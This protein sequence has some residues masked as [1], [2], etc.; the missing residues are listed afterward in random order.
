MMWRPILFLSA[1]LIGVLPR[2]SLD[3]AAAQ[4]GPTLLAPFVGFP[5]ADDPRLKRGERLFNLH[6][7]P[8]PPESEPGGG[9]GPYFNRNACSA[10]HPKGGRGKAPSDPFEPLLTA[11]IRLSV[12]GA[13]DNGAPAPHPAFGGQL[14]TR[15]LPGLPEEPT[16]EISYRIIN[17]TYPDG[18]PYRLRKPEMSFSPGL[19]GSGA[20]T[21][22]RIGQPIVG[23]GLLEA[24]PEDEI[25]AA[26]DPDDRDGDGISGRA[27]RVWSRTAGQAVLGRFGWKANE[28]DLLQQTAAAFL[29]D[30]GITSPLFPRHDCGTEQSDCRDADSGRADLSGGAVAAVADY[31]RALTPPAPKTPH[32]EGRALFHD[33]GCAAC[34]RPTLGTAR[35]AR[36]YLDGVAVEAYT[37]LL[38]HDMGEGLADGRPDFLA[39]GQEWRTPP[40]WG[41]GR[42]EA[43]HGSF[44]LLHDG[45]A[46]SPADAILW[47]GGEA[48]AA[49]DAFMALPSIDRDRLIAFLLS[50]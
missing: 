19:G 17:G 39:G 33:I 2:L 31:L 40:L 48:A 41:L 32:P 10:C 38:L 34:H 12:P 15:N 4:S 9:L 36:P 30:I 29:G 20:M 3:S 22:L 45:R 25:V 26:A 8:T 37:D 14:A 23:L 7:L 6:F 42:V 43:V 27:N 24:V 49:R 35:S 28:P 18:T 21:S 50:L 5:I 44:A 46:Q 13:A 16:A 1:V 11:L 47:H